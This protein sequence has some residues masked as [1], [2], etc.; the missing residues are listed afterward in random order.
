M[1]AVAVAGIA[2]RCTATS[3]TMPAFAVIPLVVGCAFNLTLLP[4]PL[5][6][7]LEIIVVFFVISVLQVAAM[8]TRGV[9]A[10][11]RVPNCLLRGHNLVHG[12]RRRPPR[13][14]V[15]KGEKAAVGRPPCKRSRRRPDILRKDDQKMP[16]SIGPEILSLV[17]RGAFLTAEAP[18]G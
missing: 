8:L 11:I 12:R 3:M 16:N 13:S 2:R 17:K 5:S 18:F 4:T 10:A 14:P 7:L 6:H 1:A 9:I 15:T